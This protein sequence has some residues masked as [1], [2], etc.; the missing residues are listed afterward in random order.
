MADSPRLKF[1]GLT[2]PADVAVC[3]DAGAWAIGAI[4]TP[5]GPRALG[6]DDAARVMA[7]V[8]EGVERVG[9]FVNPDPALVSDSVR[10]CGLT[11]VQLHDVADLA[12]IA[13]AAGVPITLSIRLDGP[14]AIAAGDAAEC[15][16]VLFDAA[17]PG[18]AGGTGQLADWSL[19]VARR[20][21][22]PFGLAGGLNPQVVG[23]AIRT[24]RPDVIDVASGV[25]SSPG[26][27]DPALVAAFARAA[28]EA[29]MEV[30]A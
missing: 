10:R 15:D 18:M 13:D 22:R 4:M 14:G 17:V 27:K 24:V 1:C 20:P 29:A 25:E 5:H 28:R 16:M 9:V 2:D 11:R 26:H 3:V 7:A 8:P 19:L 21:A 23:D 6:A 30:A 12:A